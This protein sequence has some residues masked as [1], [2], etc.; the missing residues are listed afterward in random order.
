MGCDRSTR[1]RKS[2]DSDRSFMGAVNDAHEFRWTIHT[3]GCSQGTVSRQALL[4]AT[5]MFIMM[6]NDSV[7]LNVS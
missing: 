7:S 1:S 4:F 3:R 5:G 6:Q 2:A